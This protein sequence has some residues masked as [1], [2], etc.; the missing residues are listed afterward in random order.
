MA[1][2]EKVS[3]TCHAERSEASGVGRVARLLT[4]D[5]SRRSA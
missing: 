3:L 2:H 5:A 4:G 1:L